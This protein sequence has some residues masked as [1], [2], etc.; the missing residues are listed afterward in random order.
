MVE[1]AQEIAER[2]RSIRAALVLDRRVTGSEA[3]RAAEAAATDDLLLY[4]ALSAFGGRPKFSVLPPDVQL[5]CP[6]AEE[7]RHVGR[8]R[9]PEKE[10][11]RGMLQWVLQDH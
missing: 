9:R 11:R 5:G 8:H 1:T 2:F 6:L 7:P 3:C 10:P 4:L